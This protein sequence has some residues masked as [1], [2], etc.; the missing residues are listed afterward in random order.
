MMESYYFKDMDT[1]LNNILSSQVVCF[2]DLFL[3]DFSFHV[4]TNSIFCLHY[5][6]TA[7]KKHSNQWAEALTKCLPG[8][9][10]HP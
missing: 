6:F 2:L 5:C 1:K 8:H 3:L 9:D 10:S 4:K 7:S